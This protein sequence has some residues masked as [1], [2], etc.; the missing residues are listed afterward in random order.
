MKY[1][2]SNSNVQPGDKITSAGLGGDFP[3]GIL[4]GYVNSVRK[5]KGESFLKAVLVP[6]TR[7]SHLKEVLILTKDKENL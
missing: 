3:S 1:L 5:V 6:A 4:L 2:L 7:L